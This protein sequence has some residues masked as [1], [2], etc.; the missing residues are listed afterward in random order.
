MKQSWFKAWGWV[1]RPVSW[2]G[3]VAA[4]V[5]LAFCV[6]VFV[7]VDSHSHS[8]SDTLYGVF[9]FVVCCF[10]LLNWLASKTCA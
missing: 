2:Q 1:Y 3:Y 6:Q 4:L 8:V 9:P 10:L 5:A 7:A